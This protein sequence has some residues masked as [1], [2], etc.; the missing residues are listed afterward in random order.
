MSKSI[1]SKASRY[2]PT[3]S[4]EE[5]DFTY[6]S[7]TEGGQDIIRS[8]QSVNHLLNE[9]EYDHNFGE[10]FSDSAV[11][12]TL[13][14]ARNSKWYE[15]GGKTW[16]EVA[17]SRLDDSQEK[18]G[19]LAHT[20]VETM[21]GLLG[22]GQKQVQCL[23]DIENL[24]AVLEKHPTRAA[25]TPQITKVMASAPGQLLK[26][27][28]SP[29]VS[30]KTADKAIQNG[31]PAEESLLLQD[32]DRQHYYQMLEAFHNLKFSVEILSP[33]RTV[34]PQPSKYVERM[35]SKR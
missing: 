21:E 25:P 22:E 20:L 2:L 12:R 8:L 35:N 31:R 11:S 32:M 4:T 19:K 24:L 23:T 10:L 1:P 13:A 16:R 15:L 28:I 5:P 34:R 7:Q 14:D 33:A 6:T 17:Y 29:P 27:L 30:G 9:L 3:D 26:L 18:L